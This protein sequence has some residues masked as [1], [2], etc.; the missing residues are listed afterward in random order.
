[1]STT[2]FA[3]SD[4]NAALLEVVQ[5]YIQD[6]VPKQAKLMQVIKTND[7]VKYMNDEFIV[8]IRSNRHT[9]VANLNSANNKLR[10]GAAPTTRGT[11]SPKLLTAT[12]DI[13][14]VVKKASANDKGAV[15]S[16]MTFQMRA[17]KNDFV[18]S[19]NRQFASDGVGVVAQ[20]AGS[21]GAGTLTVKYPDSSL[22]DGRSI[23][24]YGTINGDIK[25]TKY[26]SV[27]T[28]GMAIGIG[29]AVADVGTITSISYT[30]GNSTGTVVVTGS[31]AIVANDAV[32]IVDG[33]EE[34]SNNEIQG[35]AAALSSGT[36]SYA[37]LS[38]D[39]DIW[40]PQIMG[41]DGNAALTIADMDSVY[42][43]AVEYAEE[44]DRYA[45]FMNKSLYTK[46]GNLLTALRR[47]VNKTELVS[48][49]SGLEYEA[50]QGKVGVFLDY[51]VRDGEAVL[52]NLDT[53]T[54]C[55]VAD[56]S[57]VEDGLLRRSDY[58]TFQKVFSWYT[59][60]FC[61][62]PA[63]NGRLLRRTK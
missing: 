13:N 33:D 12:F 45:W 31:P 4:Y 14:D 35:Y 2:A 44:G 18:K 58:I 54:V 25:P 34:G 37:G 48:G 17:I 6:N 47:T 63:A 59:N 26:L 38:R 5:P 50:G 56:M 7:G 36:A 39:L 24:W 46:Y 9:G 40:S 30:R 27:G 20:V 19:A 55:Q 51:E 28:P 16:A 62:C 11:V 32:Y 61:K 10:T 15:E 43:D 53:W 41:E 8:P 29:T 1:M 3:L 23:D 42:M 49:W 21:V 52:L 57:F 22:D 60:L